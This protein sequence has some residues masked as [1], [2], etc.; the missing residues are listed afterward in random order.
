MPESGRKV[1]CKAPSDVYG[2]AVNLLK[3]VSCE[4]SVNGPSVDEDGRSVTSEDCNS[5]SYI[6][7]ELSVT[8]AVL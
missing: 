5:I 6:H 8:E 3:V 1:P 4:G 2:T 7:C